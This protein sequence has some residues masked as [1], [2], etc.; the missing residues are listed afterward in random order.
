[1]KR[2]SVWGWV[3][4]GLGVAI[5]ILLFAHPI[6][7]TERSSYAL[8]Q[9]AGFNRPDHYPLRPPTGAKTE[10]YRPI[11][12]WVGRL[13]LPELRAR[14]A[15]DWVWFEVHQAPPDSQDLIGKTVKLEW[16]DSSFA[17]NYP[18]IVTTNVRLSDR[19]RQFE[20]MGNLIPT[21]LDGWR[22]VGPLESLAGARPNNDLEASLGTVKLTTNT[23][24]EPVLRT[25]REPV[26]VTGRMYGLVSIVAPETEQPNVRPATCPVKQRLCES[27]LYRVR[28]YNPQTQQ[29]DGPEDVIRIPQQPP[30]AGGRFFST[31]HQLASSSAG[32]AGWY[33]YG[34]F[35][36]G[37]MFTV[38]AIKP[39][40]LV[41][42]AP[43][44][45]LLGKRRGR[46]YISQHNWGDMAER[47]GS[48]HTVLLDP[49]HRE[50]E[51]AIADWKEGDQA[52]LIHLFGGIGGENG[53]PVMGW[54]VTGHYSYG[55]AQVVREPLT[56][57]LQFDMT[58][59]QIYANNTNG[60][61]SGSLDWT[62]Y[63]GDL[64]R[65]WMGSRPVSD[66]VI[67]LDALAR[68]FKF[69]DQEVPVSILRE[70]MLQ[71][72]VIA[73][74]YRT[75]DGTGLAA[76]T[77]AT[78]CVQDSSQALYIALSRLQQ[79]ILK[80]PDVLNWIKNHPQ[81]P[82]TRRFQRVVEL[83]KVL[84]DLLV[85]RGVVRPDWEK[86]AEFLAGISG[87]GDLG[88]QSTLRNALLSWRSIL[89]R[90]AHDEVSRI[91][92]NAGAQLWFLR[93]DQ[94]GG[95]D[96]SIEPVAPTMALG[97]LPVFSKLLNRLLGAVLA[98][99]RFHEWAVFLLILG[100]YAA[101]AIPI[102]IH[103]GFLT[104][105]YAG[106][107]PP[108]TAILLVRIFFLPALVE[109]FGRILI[110]PHPTEG[111]SYLAWWLWANLAL[112]VYVIYH[113][114]NARMFYHA[115]YPLFFSKPFLLL[116]TLLGI[117]CTALYGFTGSLMGLV[118]F[119]WAVVAVWI[120][121]LGGYQQ[122]QPKKT[123]H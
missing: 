20:G 30:D 64:Q 13:I 102:G 118:L 71:T 40:S 80:R 61:V 10:F 77:P 90:Q 99:F 3:G 19:A 42:L 50:A 4:L 60:I 104:P 119:H 11:K 86:N 8:S 29:F 122:L 70:L 1:M 63:M 116:C 117:A 36:A 18:P 113:P 97:Q 58:Y 101:I 51:K 103:T 28:H 123:A 43:G 24:G 73:A 16:G 81:D 112:F 25:E 92:L 9:E 85:P 32:R 62:A 72:Q 65:G 109:E 82:E 22:R 48:L 115:G 45:V 78:S 26:Q 31:P 52:L 56:Q 39:R 67:K 34:A 79:E 110:L 15:T 54:T 47:K 14:G 66:I 120:L 108:Q 38:Q 17:Q 37:G 83:G 93:T 49:V 53:D 44:E 75:G 94:V 2:R 59:Q 7:A 33:I 68:P 41:Q 111:M 106:L 88:R 114:L 21:R 95:L 27:E 84:N 74:R 87:S 105:T 96:P 107:T 35:D 121:L 46:T 6:N 100:V 23:A 5:A 55:I 69:G 89:P 12:P 76:V 91:L 98:P 57:E